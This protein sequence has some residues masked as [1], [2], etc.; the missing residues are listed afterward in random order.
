MRYYPFTEQRR[1]KW[2][3]EGR[4]TG[5]QDTWN[6]WLHRG[7]FSSSGN[8]TL[9]PAYASQR[10]M[11]WFSSL[12]NNFFLIART[13]PST[14]WIQDQV[15][16]DR[17]KSR[18][19]CKKLGIQHPRDPNSLVD[20]VMTTDCVIHALGSSGK[21]IRIPRSVKPA[22]DLEVHNQ[23]EHAE[24]ERRLWL[25]EG[26]E[27]R[28]YSTSS[29]G[30]PVLLKNAEKLYMHRDLDAQTFILSY[31]G[32]FDAAAEIVREEIMRAGSSSMGL[33]DFATRLNDRRGWPP[34][35][36]TSIALFLLDRHQ[37]KARLSEHLLD[38]YPVA[39]IAALTLEQ[40]VMTPQALTA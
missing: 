14:I 25:D 12:E 30:P 15:P 8:Q 21:K 7:D 10:L 3:K 37:L 16:H 29:L 11:H 31:P 2:E 34:G 1:V 27:L 32:G 19:I 9:Q 24:V 40:Q 36:A 20:I 28:F 33:F 35:T 38:S 18:H 22:A 39:K 13:S 4:G 17:E 26:E 23:M 6:A 5:T